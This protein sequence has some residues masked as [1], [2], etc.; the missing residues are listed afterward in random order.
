MLVRTDPEKISKVIRSFI[1]NAMRRSPS[2]LPIR[3]GT[4]LRPR[5]LAIWV[6]DRGP[7][8]TKQEAETAFEWGRPSD[9]GID[10]AGVR[11]NALALYASS[12]IVQAHGGRVWVESDDDETR[13]YLEL[14]S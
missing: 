1:C 9:D 12:R 4:E 3:V 7:R 2:T 10:D 5:G 11:A 13:V 8:L 14:S 6:A